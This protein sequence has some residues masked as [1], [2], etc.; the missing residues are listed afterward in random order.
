MPWDLPMNRE[1]A[2]SEHGTTSGIEGRRKRYE[3]REEIETDERGSR[4]WISSLGNV[5][6]IV[7]LPTGGRERRL[8]RGEAA[9]GRE[10]SHYARD[11]RQ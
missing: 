4:V 8:S 7:Y 1:F 5:G 11:R 10:G 6:T 2:S 9:E 3:E